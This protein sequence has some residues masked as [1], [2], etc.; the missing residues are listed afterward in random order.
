MQQSTTILKMLK[1]GTI[2]VPDYQRA[3]SWDTPE[4][5]SDKKTQTDVFVR[6]LEE[7]INSG[8]DAP[9]YFGH[10]IYE[11]QGDDKYAIVDGQQRLTTIII[12]LSAVFTHFEKTRGLDEEEQ[13]K[14][15]LLK[16]V[17]YTHSLR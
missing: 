9:Y 13:R 8:T 7:H 14:K 17:L 4:K 16:M 11:A 1:E 10:F 6:D 2:V 5:G 15:E 3:Y 12:F